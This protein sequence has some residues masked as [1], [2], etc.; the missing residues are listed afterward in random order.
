MVFAKSAADAAALEIEPDSNFEDLPEPKCISESHAIQIR[1][2]LQKCMT[3]NLSVFKT[4]A[5]IAESI[6]TIDS[7]LAEYDALP[8][9]PYGSYSLE[10]HNLLLAGR[11]VASGA[12]SRTQNVGL[13]FNADL[14]TNPR[15]SAVPAPRG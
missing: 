12:H 4:N 8:M 15:D 3:K 9:A 6:K 10:T 13:H 2:S 5:G 14:E 11:F 7:L 1:H